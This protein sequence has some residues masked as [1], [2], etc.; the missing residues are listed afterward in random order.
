M[1]LPITRNADIES[2]Q[3]LTDRFD[4]T[5]DTVL[6]AAG[7]VLMPPPCSEPYG[8]ILPVWFSTALFDEA[9][10]W[11]HR[12]GWPEQGRAE[13]IL[14]AGKGALGAVFRERN[15]PVGFNLSTIHASNPTAGYQDTTIDVF[16][17]S[18][19][20][21][22]AGIFFDLASEQRPAARRPESA[23]IVRR[24]GPAG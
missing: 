8:Y 19:F 6:C 17:G 24:R 3:D 23:R 11:P 18:D 16:V 1:N 10:A 14:W 21:G 7:N 4:Y 20:S 22:D 5:L 9:V 12:T 13:D 15:T 2:T